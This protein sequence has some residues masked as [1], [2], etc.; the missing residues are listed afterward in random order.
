MSKTKGL[1]KKV[2]LNYRKACG[3]DGTCETCE[4]FIMD[5]KCDKTQ[6]SPVLNLEFGKHS[7]RVMKNR[8]PK[9]YRVKH[10]FTCWAWN[11]NESENYWYLAVTGEHDAVFLKVD[12]F[13]GTKEECENL[14]VMKIDLPVKSIDEEI[15]NLL[16]NRMKE[17]GAPDFIINVTPRNFPAERFQEM[18]EDIRINYASFQQANVNRTGT[19]EQKLNDYIAW[20]M[21]VIDDIEA[22]S[23][24]VE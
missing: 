5:V 15:Y 17:R 1:E 13:D 20:N 24:E 4:H 18:V 19:V 10:D 9:R 14:G 3:N 16:F 22:E 12:D 8:R 2:E 11:S 7:C 21:E 6:P 23:V